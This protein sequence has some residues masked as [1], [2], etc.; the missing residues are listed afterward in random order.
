MGDQRILGAAAPSG[1]G[2]FPID[3]ILAEDGSAPPHY[4]VALYYVD[5][6]PTPWGD[7]QTQ[8]ANRTQ[9]AYLLQLPS[10][11]PLSKRV[12]VSDFSG[13]VWHI[14]NISGSFRIRTSTMRGDYAVISA[15]AF[16]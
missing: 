1:S 3:V 14:Y 15:L 16:E 10:L 11:D 2:S 6:G 8:T 7:G 9:E 12:V 13:G 4:Q 5:F